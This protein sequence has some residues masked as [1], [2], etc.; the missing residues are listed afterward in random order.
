[1]RNPPIV[2]IITYNKSEKIIRSISYQNGP[3]RNIQKK[4]WCSYSYIQVYYLDIF[5]CFATNQT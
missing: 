4:K 5:L 2:I 3:K 1:M